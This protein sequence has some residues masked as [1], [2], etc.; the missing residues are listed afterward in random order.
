MKLV[1][2]LLVLAWGLDFYWLIAPSFPGAGHFHWLDAAVPLSLGA[3][4]A[5]IFLGRLKPQGVA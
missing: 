2:A 1:A 3:F 4:W 5:A